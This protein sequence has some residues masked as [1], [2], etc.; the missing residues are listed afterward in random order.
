M[1]DGVMNEIED[2]SIYKAQID[3]IYKARGFRSVDRL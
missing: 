2:G 3:K 1:Y